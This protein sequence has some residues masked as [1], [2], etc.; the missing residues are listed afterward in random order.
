MHLTARARGLT[1]ICARMHTQTLREYTT[2][3]DD[4][5]KYK[6]GKVEEELQAEATPQPLMMGTDQ[7]MLTAPGFGLPQGMPMAGGMGGYGGAGVPG[8]GGMGYG[9]QMPGMPLVLCA[10]KFSLCF[11]L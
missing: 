8:M 11:L 7:L 3:V 5:E 4:L 9:A 1:H 2:K 10:L 6:K